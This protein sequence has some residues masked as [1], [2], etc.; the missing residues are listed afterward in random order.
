MSATAVLAPE[1]IDVTH[2]VRVGPCRALAHEFE[3]FVPGHDRFLRD[4]GSLVRPF[5]TRSSGEAPHRYV[6]APEE[7]DHELLVLTY[8]GDRI[9]GGPRS[10]DFRATL[11][12]HINRQVIATSV[13]HYVL[14]HSAAVTR[15]GHTIVMPA[16]QESGKT[17]TT[18]GLLRQGFDYVTDEAVAIH[19]ADLTVSPFPKTL[20]L[21][22]GSWPLFPELRAAHQRPDAAQWHVPATDLGAV[23]SDRTLPAPS[24]VVIPQYVGG[25]RTEV[26][27]L[28]AA[29]AAYE[30][31]R[32]TFHFELHPRRNLLAISRLVRRATVVRL[33][34]GTLEDAVDAVDGLLSQRILED[35]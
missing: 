7:H 24:I 4:L 33:R 35:L 22:P 30:L 15:A 18:A 16:D 21:D 23:E 28:G 2:L 32:M 29:E 6:L 10:R 27:Q 17:T 3:L 13:A 26:V 19:P 9:A 34:I 20:S 8:D 5:R 12:W 11:A 14:M 25:P 31:A 1:T